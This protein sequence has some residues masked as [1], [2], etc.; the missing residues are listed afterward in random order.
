MDNEMKQ[1][2]GNTESAPGPP[3]WLAQIPRPIHGVTEGTWRRALFTA[4]DHLACHV[5]DGS[6]KYDKGVVRGCALWPVID[7]RDGDPFE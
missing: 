5:Y 3:P 1:N 4:P 7:P 2:A 6:G